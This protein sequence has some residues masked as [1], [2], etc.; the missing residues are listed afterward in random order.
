MVH[1]D[2]VPVAS[3]E[4][5]CELNE[6]ET[7]VFN[8]MRDH[9]D[10]GRAHVNC[11]PVLARVARERAQDMAERGYFSHVD[12]D[13]HGPNHLVTA[14]GFRLPDWYPDSGTAN[15]IE[16]IG[17]GFASPGDIWQ[18]WLDSQYHRIHVLGT[19][20][21]YAGQEEVGIG[22]YA[23]PNSLYVEYW[24]VITAPTETD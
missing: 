14:A 23:D 6:Q 2:L 24:V 17:A 12:P 8:M 20:R 5:S 4:R 16:S 13:G 15:N 19:D 11:N 18:A 1:A 21:F 7:A 3:L 22:Y 10:Q 9:P